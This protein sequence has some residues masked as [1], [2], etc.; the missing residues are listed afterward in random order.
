M[1][2]KELLMLFGNKA[3]T[4]ILNIKNPDIIDVDFKIIID[5]EE[6]KIFNM[7]EVPYLWEY[8]GEFQ[9]IAFYMWGR[10]RYKIRV[11]NNSPMTIAYSENTKKVECTDL[12]N[13]NYLYIEIY[14]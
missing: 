8:E 6:Y 5:G 11:V 3:K 13:D 10:T 7:Y 2:N 12:L 14:G 9:N 1:L 4:F